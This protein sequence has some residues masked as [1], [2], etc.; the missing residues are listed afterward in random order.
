MDEFEELLGV[1]DQ[2]RAKLQ[3]WASGVKLNSMNDFRLTTRFRH[4]R[5]DDW[6]QKSYQL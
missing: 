3:I 6:Q 4:N 1:S 2:G 5:V